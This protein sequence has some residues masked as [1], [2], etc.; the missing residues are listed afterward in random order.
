MV[1]AGAGGRFGRPAPTPVRACLPRACAF[2][3]ARVRSRY[4][5]LVLIYPSL[6]IICKTDVRTDTKPEIFSI[7]AEIR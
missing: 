2:F 7:F 6:F 4:F 1:V 5:F 3:F